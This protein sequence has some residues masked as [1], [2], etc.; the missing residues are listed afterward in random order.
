MKINLPPQDR[1]ALVQ[2]IFSRVAPTYDLLNHLLSLGRDVFWRKAT[3]RRVRLFRTN[4]VLD[5]AS[6]TGDLALILAETHPGARVVGGDFTYAMLEVARRKLKLKKNLQNIQFVGADALNLPLPDGSFDS[7]TIAFGIRN[8]P[9]RLAAL[10][11]MA[12]VL[13]PGGRALVLELT[14]PRWSFIRRF[15]NTYLN[16]LLP[17]VGG[18]V[19]GQALAYQY[20]A[21]SIM[22]FPEPEEFAGLMAEAGLVRASWKKMTFGIVVLHWAEKPED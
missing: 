13:T 11:E 1:I 6:G 8:I 7:T 4:R 16:R 22:E 10:R 21:D 18:L 19:S 3:A 12:R 20:L 9:D 5:I 2:G 14:F 17:K 15:Y